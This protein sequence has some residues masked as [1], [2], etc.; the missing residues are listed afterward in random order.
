MMDAFSPLLLLLLVAFS[1][2]GVLLGTI[3]GLVPGFHPNNVAFIL[4]A[5]SPAILAKLHFL[6]ALVVHSGTTVLVLVASIILAASVAHTFLNF[7]PAAFI[8]APEGDTALCVLPAHQLLLEGRAYEATVLSAT[9]SFGAV[10]FSFL[11]LVPFY[12]VFSTFQFYEIIQSHMLYILIGISALLILTESFSETMEAYQAILLSLFVFLLAGLFGYLILDM[13]VHA[14]FSFRSTMLF[15]A[16]TGLFGLS[17]ILFSLFYTPD[18]PEQRI[19]EPELEPGEIAKSVVSGSVFGSMVSFLPGIT[20]AHATVMAMLARRNR[21][22]EQVI[23]TLSGVNTANVIF[24]LA[25]LFLISRAR[26]GTTM[27]ISNLLHVQPWEMVIP[28]LAL[29]YL[30]MVVLMASACSFFITKYLGE[31]FSRFFVTLPYRKI[32]MAIAVF[33]SVL[34]F[35]FTGALGLF[36]LLV[37]VCIGLI[38]IYFGVRRSNCMGVLLL[39]IIMWLW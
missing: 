29:I 12:F 13:P 11:L 7:I 34:V 24:C 25:T 9:G 19:E 4:L 30:L 38:P 3:T 26:S 1:M 6:N 39:P 27:A 17:T 18:I 16:L 23:T 20:S 5:I 10:V 35:I 36:I 2:L 32:L 15:P 28:P 8:G 22:P 37:A 14:P 33:L 21:Q 31:Q